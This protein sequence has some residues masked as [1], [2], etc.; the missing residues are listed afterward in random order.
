MYIINWSLWL[1]LRDTNEQ[2]YGIG[3]LFYWCCT[4]Y[5]M[6][7]IS[8]RIKTLLVVVI[9]IWFVATF[10][11]L[12]CMLWFVLVSVAFSDSRSSRHL[13]Q[14]LWEVVFA[15]RPPSEWVGSSVVV[16]Y[17]CDG[18]WNTR[19]V[20]ECALLIDAVWSSWWFESVNASTFYSLYD[21]YTLR[22]CL[23]SSSLFFLAYHAS[24][25]VSQSKETF[26]IPDTKPVAWTH[27]RQHLCHW[28]RV[29]VAW[30]CRGGTV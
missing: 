23:Y 13:L 30:W 9:N 20:Y 24:A 2:N 16:I 1:R 15:K 25:A 8:C 12:T 21:W 10:I 6:Y 22:F 4:G 11:V 17:W 18:C 5:R 29:A 26:G 27:W 3:H 19:W 28:D 7:F 14:R